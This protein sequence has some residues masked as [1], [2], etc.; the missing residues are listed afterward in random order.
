MS[1][2]APVHASPVA[3][4]CLTDDEHQEFP[5]ESPGTNYGRKTHP[6]LWLKSLMI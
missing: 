3:P 5:D 2:I 6:K 1:V 4:V